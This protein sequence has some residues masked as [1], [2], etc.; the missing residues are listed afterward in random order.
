MSSI[1]GGHVAVPT[2]GGGI[3]NRNCSPQRKN[4]FLSLDVEVILYF[5]QDIGE[6]L[7]LW[8]KKLKGINM[9]NT[10]VASPHGA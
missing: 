3:I 2:A 9:V 7:S 5:S 6:S 1:P 4:K 8:K 10:V